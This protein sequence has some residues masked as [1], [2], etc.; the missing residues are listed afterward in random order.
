MGV[1]VGS[2]KCL[3]AWTWRCCAIAIKSAP[4]SGRDMAMPCPRSRWPCLQSHL[5]TSARPANTEKAGE[6]V[7]SCW[8]HRLACPL[9]QLPRGVKASNTWAS[10]LLGFQIGNLHG[11]DRIRHLKPKHLGIEEQLAFQAALDVL[12]LAEAMLLAFE[13]HVGNG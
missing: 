7:Q 5:L 8:H 9:Y 2:R 10:E 4:F 6:S 11:L 13:G 12:G 1:V 3:S